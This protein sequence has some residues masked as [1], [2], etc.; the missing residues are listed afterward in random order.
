VLG[1]KA[2]RPLTEEKS[3]VEM[4][5]SGAFNE[6]RLFD[7]GHRVRIPTIAEVAWHMPEGPFT[8]WR[9]RVIEF[10]VLP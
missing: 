5:W 3:V 10:S 6:Y 4:Q 8:Y 1:G 9:G 7:R 2:N